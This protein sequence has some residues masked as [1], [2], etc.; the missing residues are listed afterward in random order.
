MAVSAG[1]AA[2]GAAGASWFWKVSGK[3]WNDIV[4]EVIDRSRR[5]SIV[6]VKKSHGIKDTVFKVCRSSEDVDVSRRKF[7]RVREALIARERAQSREEDTR[8]SEEW[9]QHLRWRGRLRTS[10]EKQTTSISG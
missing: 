1:G 9:E 5:K 3:F 4:N 6:C 10:R 8:T 2:T 7:W